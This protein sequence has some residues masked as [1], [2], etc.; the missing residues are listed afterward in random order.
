MDNIR[1][2]LYTGLI[3]LLL[4]AQALAGVVVKTQETK[5][6]GKKSS[7]STIYMEGDRLRVDFNDGKQDMTVIFRDDKQLFWVIN[8]NKGTYTEMTREQMEAMAEQVGDAM[9][10]VNAQMA[11]AMKK[12]EKE[13]EGMNEKQKEMMR[14]MMPN[15]KNM[16]GQQGAE[17]LPKTTYSAQG[18]ATVNAWNT[19]HYVGT[20]DGEKVEEVWAAEP[21]EMG[22][23]KNDFSAFVKMGEFFKSF[24][25]KMGVRNSIPIY[26]SEDQGYE[27]LPVKS[28]RFENGKVTH[29]TEVTSVNKESISAGQF[30]LDSNLKKENMPTMR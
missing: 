12:M 13:M 5:S 8:K 3:A 15:L 24:T 14:K 27:G 20:E 4:V 21:S 11:E 19:T 30:E 23:S 1:K 29:T 26:G 10:Q 2:M 28:V 18:S 9:N 7:T 17:M 25:D 16:G 6:D 22:L